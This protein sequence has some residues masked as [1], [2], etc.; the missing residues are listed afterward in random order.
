MK[1]G[2]IKDMNDILKKQNNKTFRYFDYN[3]DKEIYS[4]ELDQFTEGMVT[5]V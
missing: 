2:L 3:C 4:M 1:D 5:F